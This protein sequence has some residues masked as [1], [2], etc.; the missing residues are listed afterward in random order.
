VQPAEHAEVGLA[1]GTGHRRPGLTQGRG[2][3]LL[4][5][6]PQ[7]VGEDLELALPGRFEDLAGQP[8]AGSEVVDQH[9]ARGAGRGRERAEAVGEP[10]LERV[11]G[12]GTPNVQGR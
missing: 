5:S 2:V 12:A 3:E 6:D 9:P 4:G 1:G 7:E 11:V 8:V 10:V